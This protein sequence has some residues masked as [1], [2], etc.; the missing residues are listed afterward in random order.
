M[1]VVDGV[2]YREAPP[3][4]WTYDAEPTPTISVAVLDFDNVAFQDSD[5]AHRF[6]ESGWIRRHSLRVDPRVAGADVLAAFS[7]KPAGPGGVN[8]DRSSIET[9]DESAF[10]EGHFDLENLRFIGAMV[11]GAKPNILAAP[12]DPIDAF[13]AAYRAGLSDPESRREALSACFSAMEGFKD[14]YRRALAPDGL[15]HR[16]MS[17]SERVRVE[18]FQLFLQGATEVAVLEAALRAR[19]DGVGALAP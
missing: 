3:P 12:E 14:A 2:L 5:D 19:L 8:A 11:L 9:R 7:R 13:R 15:V 16:D 1:R 4:C 18:R 17:P 10:P 6:D